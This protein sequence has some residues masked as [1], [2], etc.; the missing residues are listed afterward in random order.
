MSERLICFLLVAL[1]LNG[2]TVKGDE[3]WPRFRGQNGSGVN[4]S[5]LVTTKLS[6]ANQ[7]WSTDIKGVGHGS[8]VIWGDRL[9]LLSAVADEAAK[10]GGAHPAKKKGKKGKKG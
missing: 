2:V 5:H 6:Q 9:F 4:Q 3:H 10:V 1:V 8:P 7:E